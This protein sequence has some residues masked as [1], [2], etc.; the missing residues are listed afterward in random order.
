MTAGVRDRIFEAANMLY[1]ESGR[2][3]FP[4]VDAVRKRARVNMND[5]STSM[6]DW[7]RAQTTNIAPVAV[8]VPS[9]IQQAS[10]A[11]LA[12]VW[13]AAVTLANESLQAAQAGWDADRAESETLAQQMASAFEEQAAELDSANNSLVELQV[14]KAAAAQ[15]TADLRIQ[16]DATL[17]ELDTARTAAQQAEAKTTEI[18]RRVTDLRMELNHAHQ[19]AAAANEERAAWQLR[20]DREIE[21]LRAEVRNVKADADLEGARAQA[22]LTSAIATA[23]RLSGQIE[24]LTMTAPAAVNRK[25]RRKP[26][27]DGHAKQKI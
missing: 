12:D 11:A 17:H 10:N 15:E 9:V 5:A 22:A 24:A 26:A 4:T 14:S 16:L 25:P 1:E 2:V 7:R 23:A 19:L 21:G 6:K 3:V 8:Q 27:P 20:V 13:S 18:E